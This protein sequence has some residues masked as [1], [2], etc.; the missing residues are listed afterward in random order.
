MDALIREREAFKRKAM[1]LPS[2][3]A[4]KSKSD[5]VRSTPSA[6]ARPSAPKGI[7]VSNYKSMAGASA[8]KFGVLAK[9]VKH[10]RTRHQDGDVHPLTI[11]E[12]L[13]ETC[14]LDVGIRTKQ[15]LI[16][17]ALKSNPK[18]EEVEP[19]RYIFKPPYTLKDKKSLL[20][21]LKNHDL[22]GLGGILMDDVMESLPRAE[23]CIK[24]LGDEIL[25]VTRPHDKKKVLF[26]NDKSCQFKVDEDFQKLWR[27]AAV[28]GMDD[29]KI[30]EYLQKQG[31][32][33]MQKQG[34]TKVAKIP[35]RRGVRKPNK[36]KKPKDNEHVSEV[37]KFYD[38]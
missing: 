5:S 27:A 15:W 26:Y 38:N 19:G 29:E 3:E 36:Q 25:F 13:D 23:K 22:K 21:L 33:S 35:K 6:A 20:K 11:E 10:M 2:V 34:P 4:K 17:E 30:E 7:D 24:Q 14:Q 31:I 8:F 37:L 16:D 12:I 1:V 28:D 18:I 32:T 9:I